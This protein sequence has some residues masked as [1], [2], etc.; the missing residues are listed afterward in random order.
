MEDVHPSIVP[1]ASETPAEISKFSKREVCR[2]SITSM[3]LHQ[4]PHCSPAKQTGQQDGS[5]LCREQWAAKNAWEEPL[6]LL[7]PIDVVG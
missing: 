5:V 3:G 1:A 4:K 6:D 7:V 2:G